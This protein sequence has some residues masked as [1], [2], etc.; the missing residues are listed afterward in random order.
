MESA[1]EPIDGLRGVLSLRRQLDR[2]VDEMGFTPSARIW[3]T[4]WKAGVNFQRAAWRLYGSTG[5]SFNAPSTSALIRNATNGMPTPGNEESHSL[6]A[7]LGWA[8]GPWSLRLDA[9]RIQYDK[10]LN[11][12]PLGGNNGYYENRSHIRVQ[13]LE[14]TA[15]WRHDTWNLEAFARSQEG[16]DF[17]K[18]EDQQLR[19]FQNRP[20]FSAGLHGD[21]RLGKFDLAGRFAYLGHRYVYSDDASGTM[22]DRTHFMD[23]ALS[24]TYHLRRDVDL[25]LRAEHLLQ[26]PFT[27]EDWEQGKDLGAN[28]VAVL[29]GYPAPTRSITLEA[30][31]RF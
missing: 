3:Q 8:K 11:F 16:R 31:Y 27:R 23:L 29:P 19:Y 25:S 7:G 15:G 9:N 6:L 21:W 5:T 13:G 26:D 1:V 28:N 30:R 22:A 10:L 12:V 24:A 17:T 2:S 14:L 4:T 20:F 18:P